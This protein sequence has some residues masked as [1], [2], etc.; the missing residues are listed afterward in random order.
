MTQGTA[1]CIHSTAIIGPEV[2]LAPDVAV[3]PYAILEGPIRVGAGCRIHARA[4]LIGPLTLGC[5]N[6]VF[7][8]AILGAP[9]QHLGY[10]GEPTRVEIGDHN[11]FREN[12]TVHR[13]TTHS[14]V[15]KIGSHNFLM[16]GAHVAHDCIV[17]DRCILAN[18]A[19]LG[20]HCV[21]E[22]NVFV[23][24][25]AAAHQFCRLG[26]LSFLSGTSGI[27]KDL[28]PFII[29]QEINQV[30]GVNIVGMRRAGV[31]S[32]SISAVRQLYHIVYLQGRSLPN[33]LAEAEATI[34]HVPEVQEYIRFVRASTRGI[35]GVADSA[36]MPGRDLDAAA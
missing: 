19:L 1:G 7:P 11:I 3:G 22:N 27:S 16:A 14:W 15:T 5:H 30:M 8:N 12:V 28:P 33:A 32:S 9:A 35:A 24:G 13:A 26:R 29:I 6:E 25:N 36:R 18:N 31:P 23:S 20:G 17:G 2:S 21:M 34:G 10:K 4:H